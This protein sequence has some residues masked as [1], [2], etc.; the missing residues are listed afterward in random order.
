VA[1]S[2]VRRPTIQSPVV[3]LQPDKVLLQLKPEQPRHFFCT[4]RPCQDERIFP[5]R[6]S[7]VQKSALLHDGHGFAAP[8]DA[9]P[10]DMMVFPS[11]AD[12]NALDRIRSQPPRLETVLGPFHPDPE[13]VIRPASGQ[14]GSDRG[15]HAQ[16]GDKALAPTDEP[17]SSFVI[18]ENWTTRRGPLT[19]RIR[20]KL[21]VL[22][23][24]VL[25][26][27]VRVSE[28]LQSDVAAR[29]SGSKGQ[30]GPS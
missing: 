4:P 16:K 8:I 2:C 27:G 1:T 10:T 17:T 21:T 12:L 7:E 9:T 14:T 13:L 19:R 18:L 22:C 3:T 23:S 20:G 6:S 11:A 24:I 25:A 15:D 28:S 29:R 30:R 26:R 5:E